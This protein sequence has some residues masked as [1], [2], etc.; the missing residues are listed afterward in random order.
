MIGAIFRCIFEHVVIKNVNRYV[1][2]QFND[3]QITKFDRSDSIFMLVCSE[4]LYLR[5]KIKRPVVLS[6]LSLSEIVI[7]PMK[8]QSCVKL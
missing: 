2:K 3:E 7:G 1:A 6:C 8:L 5:S 4:K